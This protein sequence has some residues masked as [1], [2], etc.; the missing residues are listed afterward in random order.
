MVE[1]ATKWTLGDCGWMPV[2]R[3]YCRYV[4]EADGVSVFPV[5]AMPG[6]K[7]LL[8]YLV[9]F[10][11][12]GV[13]AGLTYRLLDWGM[14]VAGCKLYREPKTFL[15]FC[16]SPR[17][18]DYE[19]G[20]YYLDLEPEAVEEL[21]KAKVLF[22]GNSRAQFGFSTD[23]IRNYFNERSIPFYII[24]FAY[25]ESSGFATR[26]IEKYHL[27]PKVL[28][29][30]TDP[31]FD[32]ELSEVAFPLVDQSGSFLGR[33]LRLIRTR[34][35]YLTKSYFNRLQPKACDLLAMLCSSQ[36]KVI[37]RSEKD[38]SWIWRDLY[39][40]PEAGRIPNDGSK[41]M[42]LGRD[43][44]LAWKENA[45]RFLETAGARPE[46]VVLTHVPNSVHEAK[47]YTRELSHLLG[48][49]AELPE[50]TGL[51][52][53]DTSHLTW[54]SAQRW[55]GTFIRGIDSLITDCVSA[56]AVP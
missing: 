41:R 53:I 4:D 35:D 43:H 46:C 55:S 31:F 11:T 10:I 37:Y 12:T 25:G 48:T 42:V 40:P 8:I 1:V 22:L 44:A 19:H 39:Q 5:L 47:P 14:D 56:D 54:S 26:L 33:A 28:V 7:A 21:K 34:W 51:E 18:G 38:G 24:G 17:Y 50:L 2:W 52:T 32:N 15:A 3:R 30:D 23:E 6:R 20:A 9:L 13:T 27:K 49:R 45:R 16:Q 29:I 36:F